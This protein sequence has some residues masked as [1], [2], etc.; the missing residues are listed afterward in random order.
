[1]NF[2]IKQNDTLPSLESQLLD[3][4]GNPV[5]LEMCGVSVLHEGIVRHKRSI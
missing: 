5:N 1:M 4:D 2:T 3:V